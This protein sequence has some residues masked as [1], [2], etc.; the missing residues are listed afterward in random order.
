MYCD[1]ALFISENRGFVPLGN[2]EPRLK[3]QAFQALAAATSRRT[4]PVSAAAGS[5][6][7]ITTYT[8]IFEEISFEL[9]VNF[10]IK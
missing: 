6:C 1:Y 4:Q 8:L 5:A 2:A 10:C 7:N 9:V 3:K